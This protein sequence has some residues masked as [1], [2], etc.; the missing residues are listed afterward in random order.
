MTQLDKNKTYS[1]NEFLLYVKEERAELYEGVPIFMAPASFEHEGVVANLIQEIGSALKGNT[2]QVYG[3]NL[4]VI[5]PFKDEQKGKNDVTVLPDIS[6]VCD[7]SKL[8]NKRCYGAPEM[9]VEVLSPSTSRNDRL[10]KRNYYEIAGVG[11]YLIVDHQNQAIEKY[12]L[13]KDAYTLEDIYSSENQSFSST[14]FPD[15]A[16]SIE[17]IFSFLD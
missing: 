8:R 10:L 1:L 17:D 15:I 12:V 4:Q 2:C 9:I 6:I 16:F 5:F 13:H 14:R 7:K 3:S 11:E